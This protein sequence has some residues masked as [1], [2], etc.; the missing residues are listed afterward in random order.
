[1]PTVRMV[2]KGSFR[3]A[4]VIGWA[5]LFF[6]TAGCVGT[7]HPVPD[8]AVEH[9]LAPVV[10]RG[11][12]GRVEGGPGTGVA[13]WAGVEAGEGRPRQNEATPRRGQGGLVPPKPPVLPQLPPPCDPPPGAAGGPAT[14]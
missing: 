11:Q 5:L 7:G 14:G 6:G 4:G 8:T 9:L 12:P 2:L 3:W 10:G 1:M 13:E